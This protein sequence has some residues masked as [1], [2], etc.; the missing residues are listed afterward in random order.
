MVN[1]EKGFGGAMDFFG[2]MANGSMRA[3]RDEAMNEEVNGHVID[4]V[5]PGDTGR[6]ETGV[7]REGTW[8]IVEDYD[9]E[10]AAKTGHKK[11]VDMIKKNP[12]CK[13]EDTD[14]WGLNEDD[15]VYTDSDCE[16][17]ESQ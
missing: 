14:M 11:W 10:K 13:L 6:W 9:D 8:I 5:V 4:T 16:G 15:A 7:K 1:L 17:G 3:R 12:K 2:A